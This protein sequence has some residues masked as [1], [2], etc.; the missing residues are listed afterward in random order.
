MNSHEEHSH[1]LNLWQFLARIAGLGEVTEV[2]SLLDYHRKNELN[3][4]EI[5]F[6]QL[7][8]RSGVIGRVVQDVVY[9][10]IKKFFTIQGTK[11]SVEWYCHFKNHDDKI[12]LNERNQSKKV[13]N[14]SKSRADDFTFELEH[15]YNSIRF[16]KISPLSLEYGI[17]TMEILYA[18]YNSEG[19]KQYIEN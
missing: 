13:Y 11:G 15:I 9:N 3:Y 16:K 12:V 17:K 8:T 2:N 5:C 1:A 6:M 7:K 19:N 14:F 10:P 4:D 18:I